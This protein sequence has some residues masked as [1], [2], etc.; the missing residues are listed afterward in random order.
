MVSLH[1]KGLKKLLLILICCG[2]MSCVYLHCSVADRV[3]AV[4]Y[5]GARCGSIWTQGLP[6]VARHHTHGEPPLGVKII[7]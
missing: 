1:S 2:Y 3:E 7:I 5:S 4:Q 6:A